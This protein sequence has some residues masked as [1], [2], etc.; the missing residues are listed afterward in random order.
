[1]ANVLGT[2]FGDI[3]NAIREKTGE[4]GT[5]KPN[6]FPVKIA[7]IPC[8]N[9]S[10]TFYTDSFYANG[11]EITVEHNIG[12]IPDILVVYTNHVPGFNSLIIS[13]G[14]SQAM[15]NALGEDAYAPTSYIITDAA[16]TV[17]VT[18]GMESTSDHAADF[19]C[20]RAVTDTTFV[21]GGG[22]KS[23]MLDKELYSYFAISGIV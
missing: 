21:V 20:V 5:M 17:H 15:M 10:F 7:G 1:M 12:V 23:I 8:G 11:G 13:V 6:E 16:I 4:A 3:A 14:F 19:G 22:T 18:H 2:L 9:A